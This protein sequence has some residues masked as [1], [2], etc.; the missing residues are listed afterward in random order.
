MAPEALREK[1]REQRKLAEEERQRIKESLQ[2]THAN[3]DRRK[4]EREKLQLEKDKLR[5]Q[6]ETEIERRKEELRQQ[7]DKED[8]LRG[9][10]NRHLKQNPKILTSYTRSTSKPRQCTKG[11]EQNLN[12]SRKD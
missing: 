4:E 7:K 12:D 3:N 1:E 8:Q 9:Q 5:R 11:R 2:T 6:V 10:L